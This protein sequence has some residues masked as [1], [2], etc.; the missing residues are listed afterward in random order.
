MI[1]YTALFSLFLHFVAIQ[2]SSAQQVVNL[3]PNGHPTLQGKG[4]TEII[5]PANRQP[6]GRISSIKNVHVPSIEVRMPPE[7]KSNGCAIIVAPGGG[8]SQL[9]W[10]SEG[11]DIAEW[12]NA[13][14]ITAFI[15]KYRLE[16]T[17]NFQYTVEG[18]ALQDTQRA[19]RMVRMRAGEWKIDPARVG[20]LGFS[21][22]GALGALADIRFDSGKPD[23]TDA[24]E[25]VSCR[26]DFIALVYPGW[27]PMDI[28]ARADSAPAFLTSAGLDDAFH[29]RQTVEFHNELFKKGV[30]SEL[31]IYAH[32][33]HGG[34]ISA[35]KG[36]P[37]GTWHI[38]FLEWLTDL[39]MTKQQ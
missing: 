14:G 34:A 37:F 8:H 13:Q 36:I 27:K 4:E 32:G 38:R 39:G 21:A 7:G 18:E 11:T 26:P 20:V 17:P 25:K 5:L 33:G 19:I 2:T 9:V 10:G 30:Q 6:G 3:Y 23:S 12:L 16:Q 22:G 35:R 28:T 29:A 15:L 31:H 24:V 1:R